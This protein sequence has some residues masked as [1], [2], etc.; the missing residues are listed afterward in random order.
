MRDRLKTGEDGGKTNGA[1]QER[2]CQSPL[3]TV[4]GGK[5]SAGS[6]RK[7]QRQVFEYHRKSWRQA[8]NIIIKIN[9]N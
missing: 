6:G 5:V 7:K 9:Y 2:R 1:V 8:G 4:L 3:S